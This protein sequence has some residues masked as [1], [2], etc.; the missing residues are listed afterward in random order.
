MK[1]IRVGTKMGEVG[2]DWG[3]QVEIRNEGR[4]I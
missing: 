4:Q 2:L 3:G 1:R